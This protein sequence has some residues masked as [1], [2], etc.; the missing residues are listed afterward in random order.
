MM[1]G[2]SS[3]GIHF[4]GGLKFV[5]HFLAKVRKNGTDSDSGGPKL[6]DPTQ[7]KLTDQC[8]PIVL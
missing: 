6:T 3:L 8:Y 2:S 5:G 4:F 7:P 1:E